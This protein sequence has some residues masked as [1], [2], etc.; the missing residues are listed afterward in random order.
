[1]ARD[2]RLDIRAEENRFVDCRIWYQANR[3]K[4]LPQRMPR[5]HQIVCVKAEL[6]KN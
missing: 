2:R 4:K 6:R 1:M 3:L 5:E